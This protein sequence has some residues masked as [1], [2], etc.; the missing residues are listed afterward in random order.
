MNN[1]IKILIAFMCYFICSPLYTYA[2]DTLYVSINLK[3]HKNRTIPV[4]IKYDKFD[5]IKFLEFP[6]AVPGCYRNDITNF[7]KVVLN[8]K[9]CFE[10]GKIK[11]TKKR[12]KKILINK[13]GT[14]KISY[15]AQ[16][17]T[18]DYKLTNPEGSIFSDTLFLLNWNRIIPYIKGKQNIYKIQITKPQYLK[19]A[20]TI[21]RE[22][23]N[24]TLDILYAD[25]YNQLFHHPVLYGDLEIYTFKVKDKTVEFAISKGSNNF[26][27][28]K[29]FNKVQNAVNRAYEISLHNPERYSFLNIISHK[30]FFGGSALEHPSCSVNALDLEVEKYSE[31][32]FCHILTHELCHALFT[33]LYVRSKTIQNFNYTNPQSDPHLWFYEGIAEYLAQKICLQS[34]VKNLSEFLEDMNTAQFSSLRLTPLYRMSKKIYNRNVL[35]LSRPIRL[36]KY[37][38]VYSRGCLI[39]WLIDIEIYKKTNGK[40]SLIDVIQR[41]QRNHQKNGYFNENELFDL[42]CKYS[43]VDL[44]PIFNNYIKKGTRI[45]VKDI[46]DKIGYQIVDSKPFKLKGK[47]IDDQFWMR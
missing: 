29:H 14:E 45:R 18:K 26:D 22:I 31:N 9:V 37:A 36:M 19:Y 1:K 35:P 46:L 43:E 44:Y 15:L 27:V 41:L 32:D 7:N 23:I 3:K 39:G 8:P 34:G 12:R 21:K 16:S 38:D 30:S 42:F 47:Y 2:N 11:K 28:K 25:N 33:P 6:R 40:L 4:E 20:G 24:D 5:S 13:K 17:T 10:N